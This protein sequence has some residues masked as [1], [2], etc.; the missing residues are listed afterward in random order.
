MHSTRSFWRDESGSIVSAEM[1]T[2]GA[3]V[4]VGAAAGMQTVSSTVDEEVRDMTRAI[5]SLDQSYSYRGFR[6]CNSM[7]A[8]SAFVDTS[9]DQKGDLPAKPPGGTQRRPAGQS[10]TAA[11]EAAE[12]AINSNE[13]EGEIDEEE[14]LEFEAK[15]ADGSADANLGDH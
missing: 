15:A 5:R 13:L 4:A 8:G 12:F 7:T 1:V 11:P 10:S 6:G 3:V 14:S 2:I 9:I